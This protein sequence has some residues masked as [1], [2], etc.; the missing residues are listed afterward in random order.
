MPKIYNTS[1]HFSHFYIIDLSTAV[2]IDLG[3][4][5]RVL[6]LYTGKKEE[7]SYVYRAIQDDSQ[8]ELYYKILFLHLGLEHF[9]KLDKL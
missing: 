9:H 6:V 4:E 1:K 7:F 2:N 5:S 8:P 3:N